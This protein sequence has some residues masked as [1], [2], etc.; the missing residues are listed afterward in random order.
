MTIYSSN[1]R[2]EYNNIL[3]NPRIA[4]TRQQ[5]V[6]K[7]GEIEEKNIELENIAEKVKAELGSSLP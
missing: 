3:S 5:L 2:E 6:D 1:L 7:A 4:T